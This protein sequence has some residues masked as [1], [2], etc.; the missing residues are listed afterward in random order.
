MELSQDTC[1][2]LQC[3]IFLLLGL[4]AVFEGHSDQFGVGC[5]VGGV[6]S[7][8]EGDVEEFGSGT[9]LL[10]VGAQDGVLDFVGHQ[11]GVVFEGFPFYR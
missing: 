6:R 7:L 5:F 3:L 8:G 4:V 1:E 10:D 9:E 11:A 2:Q